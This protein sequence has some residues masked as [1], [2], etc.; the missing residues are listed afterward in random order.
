MCVCVCVYVCMCVC[1]YVYVCMCV[2]VCVCV[3]VY[4]YV[5]MCLCLCMC[6]Y[7]FFLLKLLLLLLVAVLAGLSG[8]LPSV[9][10]E[11]VDMDNRVTFS[12]S[13]F[14]GLLRAGCHGLLSCRRRRCVRG[15]AQL[16]GSWR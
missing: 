1:V 6:V 2:C 4:V 14:F 12:I 16:L 8:S 3:Y 10:S 5:C 11:E 13:F 15:E 9:C 7:V